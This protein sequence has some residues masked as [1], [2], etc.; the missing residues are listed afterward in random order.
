M[1]RSGNAVPVTSDGVRDAAEIQAW[2]IDYLAQLLEIPPEEISVVDS[3]QEF[4]LDSAAAVGL[5]GDLGRWFGQKLE[6]T[7][8]YDYPTIG[9]LSAYLASGPQE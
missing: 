4:G 7:L 9:S 6:P 8:A 2:L 3:F 1:G 5:T